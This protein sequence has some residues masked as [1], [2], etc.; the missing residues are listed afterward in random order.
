MEGYISPCPKFFCRRWD[1][2]TLHYSFLLLPPFWTLASVLGIIAHSSQ[3]PCASHASP[4]RPQSHFQQ[5]FRKILAL[6]TASL[7]NSQCRLT[8]QQFR[9]PRQPCGSHVNKWKWGQSDSNAQPSDLES[10]A[11]PLRHS[12]FVE[13]LKFDFVLLVKN[14]DGLYTFLHLRNHR[15]SLELNRG[16]S[17]AYAVCTAM[18]SASARFPDHGGIDHSGI[19]FKTSRT[20]WNRFSKVFI[21]A[22]HIQESVLMPWHI[23]E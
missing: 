23:Q 16:S 9:K 5:Y 19:K 22:M 2:K 17:H 18:D 11:L 20:S 7:L 4:V 13:T 12:P 1:T 6:P 8:R 14:P 3:K 15:S 10:D 21:N